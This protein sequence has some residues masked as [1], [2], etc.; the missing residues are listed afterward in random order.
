MGRAYLDS[1]ILIY[2]IEGAPR[3]RESVRELMKTKMEEGFEFCFSDLTRLEARV[4]PLKSKDGRLLDLYDRFF[5]RPSLIRIAPSPTVFDTAALLRAES[6]LKT[7]DALH[8]AFAIE[9]GCDEFWTNDLHLEKAAGER[10][11]I[12]LPVE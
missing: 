6:N 2:L 1:C 12:V 3:I 7:P 11:K 10:L 9:G 4:G 5:L 8:L